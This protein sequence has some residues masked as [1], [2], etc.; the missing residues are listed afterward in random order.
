MRLRHLRGGWAALLLALLCGWLALCFAPVAQADASRVFD[1]DGLLSAGQRAELNAR[2]SEVSSRHGFDVVAAT[3]GDL[4]GK[5]ARLYAADFYEEHGFGPNGAI[6]IVSLAERDWGFATTGSGREA[7]TGDGQ[8][9]LTDFF[10]PDLRE[11]RFFEAFMGYAEGVDAFL[12]QAER[13]APYGSGNHP[14]TSDTKNAIAVGG[15]VG[16][17]VLGA[18]I[19]I[20]VPGRWR[21]KL[22]SVRPQ[23][24][25]DRYVPQNGFQ[26]QNH[27]DVLV[28]RSVSRTRRPEPQSSSGGGGGGFSSSSGGS[29]SGMSGKF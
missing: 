21:G 16:A 1:E 17:V 20:A 23:Q 7:F 5:T 18:V 9:Y 11:D 8:E 25:A 15:C 19:A 27:S 24:A 12:V 22:K 14:M 3:V 2:L 4:G 26:L 10:L 13:G 28:D 6:L 29:F